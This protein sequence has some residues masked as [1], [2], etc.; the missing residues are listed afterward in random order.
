MVFQQP[1]VRFDLTPTD[2]PVSMW[3]SIR[4]FLVAIVLASTVSALL[5]G[6]GDTGQTASSLE[7]SGAPCDG[8]LADNVVNVVS[9]YLTAWAEEDAAGMRATSAG[10]AA[11]YASYLE[12]L[13]GADESLGGNQAI[14]EFVPDAS[15]CVVASGSVTLTVDAELNFASGGEAGMTSFALRE[16]DGQWRLIEYVRDGFPLSELI[17]T[18]ERQESVSSG[19][20]ELSLLYAFRRPQYSDNVLNLIVVYA[21]DT[22]ADGNYSSLGLSTEFVSEESGVVHPV[23]GVRNGLVGGGLDFP[24]SERSIAYG[25]WSALDDVA[26]GGIVR[27]DVFDPDQDLAWRPELIVPPFD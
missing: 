21:V 20:A 6:C 26:Q 11:E 17:V 7:A 27:I 25:I 14:V 13:L 15:T 2:V 4:P 24:P 18:G 16:I 12:L 22:P 5:S 3:T 10:P 9:K 19:G 23:E 8:G 1:P